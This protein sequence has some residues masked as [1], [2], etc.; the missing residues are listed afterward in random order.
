MA[1]IVPKREPCKKCNLPV[2]LAERLVIGSDLFHRTCLK[3]ARCNTQLTVGNFYETENDNE[4]CCETCPDE[5]KD[6]PKI[7]EPNNRIS[8][9]AQRV[10]LFEKDNSV[11]KK[12]LSDEEKTKS[13]QRQKETVES[14]EHMAPAHSTALNNFLSTQLNAD[15][16][17]DGSV[18]KQEASSDSSSSEAEEEPEDIN[19][20]IE[21]AHGSDDRKIIENLNLTLSDDVSTKI[22]ISKI[23]D[24][25]VVQ[26]KFSDSVTVTKDVADEL[27]PTQMDSELPEPEFE[28]KRSETPIEILVESLNAKDNNIKDDQDVEKTPDVK[29]EDIET[30]DI[31]E[32]PEDEVINDVEVKVKEIVKDSIIEEEK[33]EIME[34]EIE[35]KRTEEEIKIEEETMDEK[36]VM[37]EQEEVKKKVEI[38]LVEGE[39]REVKIVEEKEVD[40]NA[41][42]KKEEETKETKISDNSEDNAETIEETINIS[43]KKEYPDNLNPFGS[44]D[45]DED[46]TEQ[47]KVR[48]EQKRP[49]L[50]PFG[51]CSEDENENVDMSNVSRRLTLPK[52]PR[53]PPPKIK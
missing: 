3:C 53:P 28:L 7:N 37:E 24:E 35:Q 40:E 11:L 52:P 20:E 15:E 29:I 36:K 48:S 4:Y 22:E 51:S 49:S 50:N 27:G 2:F 26:E 14:L 43:K 10:Q 16:D 19:M 18:S 9:I 21:T 1:H 25:S 47:V 39:E 44:E 45:E 30:K 6:K 12:S 33:E 46:E 34:T 31:I 32:V 17:V 5:E 23:I 41:E 13:L 42:K 38:K 8:L